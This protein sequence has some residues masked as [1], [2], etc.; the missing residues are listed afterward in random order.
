M[1]DLGKVAYAGILRCWRGNNCC[2][3]ANGKSYAT[4]PCT[5]TKCA[6]GCDKA[7]NATSQEAANEQADLVS[8]LQ[9]VSEMKTTT[10]ARAGWN[11]C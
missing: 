11:T 9:D 8:L 7:V 4:C 1:T 10:N 5:S 6:W 2:K 3:L